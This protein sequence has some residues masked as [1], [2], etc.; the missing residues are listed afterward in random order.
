MFIF[1]DN[2]E[3]DTQGDRYPQTE[4]KTRICQMKKL[5]QE[6]GG[7]VEWGVSSK[8]HSLPLP[9]SLARV[10]SAPP[11]A[12]AQ[13]PAPKLCTDV[14]STLHIVHTVLYTGGHYYLHIAHNTLLCT[15]PTY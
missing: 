9:V 6:A 14:L 8:C 5:E 3:R 4:P 2:T 12:W 1:L 15:V 11:P 13:H 7:R 10:S